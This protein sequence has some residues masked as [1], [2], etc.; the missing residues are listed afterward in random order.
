MALFA[1]LL[2]QVPAQISIL[3][4]GA[5]TV[6]ALFGT[7][8][9]AALLF[10]GIVAAAKGGGSLWDR[11]FLPVAAA[12]AGAITMHLLGSPPL[13][14]DLPAVRQPAGDRPAHRRARRVRGGRHQ[15]RRARRV[16]DRLA[17][18]HALRHP[19]LIPLVGGFLLG[20]LGLIGGPITMFKGLK[21]IGELLQDPGQYDGTPARA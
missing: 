2:P 3:I 13:A 12:G 19:I 15:P 5:A 17:G 11:L 20:I 7:P 4:A 8:V 18:L 1:R 16:P 14:F 6:G 9:A 10:T 21:Q